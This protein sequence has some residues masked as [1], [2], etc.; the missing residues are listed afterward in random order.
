[1]FCSMI[2]YIRILSSKNSIPRSVSQRG[3][4]YCISRKF[5]FQQNHSSLFIRDPGGIQEN[6]DSGKGG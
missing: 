4:T 1:M 3:A 2:R 6:N 5:I